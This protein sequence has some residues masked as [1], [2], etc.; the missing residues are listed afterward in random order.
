M[1][2]CHA[3][4]HSSF[5]I[6][7]SLFLLNSSFFILHSSFIMQEIF[8]AIALTQIEN[9]GLINAKYLY[10]TLGSATAVIE[11]RNNLDQLIPN[12]SRRA[13]EGF[14]KIDE[15]FRIAEKEVEFINKNNIKALCMKNEAYPQRLLQCDDAPIILFYCGNAD[16][17]KKKIISMVGTRNCT[18][19]GK[20]LCNT[21]IE[22]LKAEIPEAIIVSGLAYGIDVNSHRAALANDMQTI[23]VVAHGLDKIYP[24]AHRN[25]AAK[26]ATNGGILTE[27]IHGSQIEKS[28]FLKRNRIIAGMSD[29]CVVVESASHGGSLVTADIANSYSREV[30]AFPGRTTDEHSAGCNKIIKENKA[31]LIESAKDFLQAMGWINSQRK[32]FQGDLFA[33]EEANFSEDETKIIKC[34]EGVDYKSIN[35]IVNETGLNYGQVSSAIFELESKGI[36]STLGGARIKL[37]KKMF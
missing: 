10:E 28:N 24:A 34:L 2:N 13:L 6:P 18:E 17:N 20:E 33:N 35:L 4:G 15:A 7:N 29:A 23:G 36:I 1:K 9:V 16:L 31:I 21:F 14:T 22:G 8:N 37:R 11:N 19:Y 26:M 30:F 32:P 12:A 25:V 3:D 27:Y 5:F